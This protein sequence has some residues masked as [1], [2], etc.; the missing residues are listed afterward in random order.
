MSFSKGQHPK[1]FI[2]YS[3]DSPEHK[4]RV[5]YL[6]D[7]LRG[8]GIDCHI[9]QYEVSPPEGWP[10]WMINQIEGADFVLVICT[11]QYD[12]RFRGKEKVGK[13]LGGKW[14]GAIITQELYDAEGKNIKFI[15]VV[16][17]SDDEAFI[18][19][20][21]RGATHYKIDT[22][23]GYEGLYRNLS[24]QPKIQKPDLGK[25]RP[26]PPLSR[27]QDFSK[28][29]AVPY[30]RNPFF[31]GRE[32]FLEEIHV[33]L[34]SQGLAALTQPIAITGLGGI[35]KTQIAIE[36]AYRFSEEYRAV[37]W[38]RSN[39]LEE[40]FSDF[41]TITELLDLPIARAEDQNLIIAAVKRWLVGRK[42]RLASYF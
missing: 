32:E 6:S 10:H 30:P 39:T 20:M 35:G 42:K 37:L 26:M 28:L 33:N 5:L 25:L 13:G 15:P 21:L 27:K 16:F 34:I 12:R 14:E 18:P 17:S 24:N 11:E 7:R 9:D 3:H 38:V 19:L 4:D 8:D 1:V 36:Y 40:I 29:F 22:E 2:S 23:E 41:Q 31:T